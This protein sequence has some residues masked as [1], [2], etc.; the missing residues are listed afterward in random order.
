MAKET[1]KISPREQFKR[2]ESGGYN[3]KEPTWMNEKQK[4]AQIC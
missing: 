2:I 3:M 1:K 4:K